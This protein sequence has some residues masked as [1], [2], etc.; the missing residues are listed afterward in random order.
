MIDTKLFSTTRHEFDSANVATIARKFFNESSG[1]S[2]C[3]LSI[4]CS[5]KRSYEW[6]Y[7]GRMAYAFVGLMTTIIG[8]WNQNASLK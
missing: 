2:T 4:M 5:T 8:C 3:D 6:C 7:E 1:V